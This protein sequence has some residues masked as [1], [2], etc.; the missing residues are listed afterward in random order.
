MKAKILK[1]LE[2]ADGYVSG[3]ELCEK[4][5]VSR[6][7]VWKN[8]KKLK[9]EGCEI[10]AVP[11]RGYCLKHVPDLIT[12]EAYASVVESQ[13]MGKTYI[14]CREIDS[15]NEEAKRQ[16]GRLDAHGL[17]V[18]ADTQ[19]G[20]KGR[21]G[22]VW[23]SPFG[24]TIAMSLLL[25]PTIAT[26]HVSMLTL[27]AAL[28]VSQAIDEVTLLHTQIKWPNDIVVNGK[29][30]C[31]ILTEMSADMD[32]IYYV[33]IGIGIN[34]NTQEFPEE[35]RETATSLMLETD[36]TISR[37]H[38]IAKSMKYMEEN[39]ENFMRTQ[40]MSLLL[41]MYQSRLVNVNQTVRVLALGQAYTGVSEGIN[42]LGELLVRKENG[43]LQRVI[44]GEVSVRG[45][46]GYV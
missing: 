24:T 41:E 18:S 23:K 6:T 16:V 34:V 7:A 2:E 3:Q 25:K 32:Q 17:L 43:E 30:V 9:E 14:Y 4:L 40:D 38:I 36:K 1:L 45:I 29:K 15:T 8:I 35:I 21:L 42:E 27:V 46:Y 10:E 37:R 12:P 19:T 22:R 39:Y 28:S 11:N 5:G 31:G 33:V 20:G 13:W 26:T 44:S